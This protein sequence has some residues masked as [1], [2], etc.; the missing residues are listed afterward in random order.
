MKLK[1][2]VIFKDGK[3]GRSSQPALEPFTVEHGE[4]DRDQTV[5]DVVMK[6]ADRRLVSRDIDVWIG[7]D[8]G[9]VTV[10]GWRMVGEFRMSTLAVDDV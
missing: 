4:H 6:L 10:G 2:E 1:T 5:A 8:D 3:L 9:G 7:G